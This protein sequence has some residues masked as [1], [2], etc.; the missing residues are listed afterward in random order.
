MSSGSSHAPPQGR[1]RWYAVR[2]HVHQEQRADA[3]LSNQGYQSYLPLIAK[4]VRHARKILNVKAPLF[5]GYLFVSLDITQQ[6]WRPIN[7]TYGVMGLIMGGE[8]P[9]AVPHGVVEALEGLTQDNG[10]IE[11]TPAL[12][13][14]SRVHVVAGPFVGMI[15]ELARHDGKG[16]IEVLLEIM[17][18]QVRVR[19]EA[20]DLMPA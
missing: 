9:R 10:L 18:Q 4:S 11:F 1:E 3:Q 6:Q 12:Q 7:S 8:S 20:R 16:R 17:G 19:S 5:P 14:G 2:C 15:G 13:L